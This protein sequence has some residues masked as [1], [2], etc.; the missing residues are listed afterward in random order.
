MFSTRRGAITTAV[1]AALLAAILLFVFVQSYQKGGTSSSGNTPVFVASGYIPAGTPVSVI[2]SAQL[3]SRTTVPSNHVVVGAISDPSVLRGEVAAVSI[4]PGQQLTAGDFTAKA[5]GL[6][7]Q[8]TGAQRAIAIPVDSAHG[9]VGYVAAGDHVDV[10]DDSG[11]G[12]AGANGVS[13]L[14]ANV[15]VLVAPGSSGG[16]GI[17]GGGGNSNGNIILE[18]SARQASE[19]AYASDNGKV[20]I[21]LRPPLG[22]LGTT[23]AGGK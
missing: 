4:Y 14:A 3:L 21:I 16:N 18:V 9:L 10:L 22:A 6:A 5:V 7:S 23:A 13:L 17:A 20:W 12:R 15:P 2:A 19:F 11:A 1:V 8:L